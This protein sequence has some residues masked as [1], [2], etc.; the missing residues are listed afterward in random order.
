[1]AMREVLT[2][3]V[4]EHFLRQT[5]R[6]VES[7]DD[8]LHQLLDDMGETLYKKDGVGLAAPQVGVRRRVIVVDTGDGLIELVNPEITWTDGQ[9]LGEEGCLS[10]PGVQ[11]RVM[12]PMSVIVKAVD[13]NGKPMELT[14]QGLKARA[15]CHEVDHLNGILFID[16]VEE[17]QE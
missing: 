11:K 14:G 6:P 13:R 15:F 1:L 4:W 17:G 16:R 10:V 3:P 2:I 5:A 7:F 9:Q 12:R 8:R